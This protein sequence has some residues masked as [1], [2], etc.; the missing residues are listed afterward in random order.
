MSPVGNGDRGR[1]TLGPGRL[2]DVPLLAAVE[3]D[4]ALGYF[5]IGYDFCATG[6]IREQPEHGRALEEGTVAVARAPSGRPVGFALVWRV[7]GRAHLLELGVMRAWQ[8]R[9]AGRRLIAAAEDWAV[10]AGL[11]E[12]TLTAYRDVPWNAPWYGRL[13]YAAFAPGPDRAELRAIQAEEVFFAQR[14]R[15]AMRKRLAP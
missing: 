14:P 7:D 11:G 1:W 12:M 9:G 10:G 8:G 15:V 2:A 6:P 4:A 5:D 3:R 13:G